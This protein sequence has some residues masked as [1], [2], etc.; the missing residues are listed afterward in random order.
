MA[1]RTPRKRNKFQPNAD[2]LKVINLIIAGVPAKK[3]FDDC[4]V[5]YLMG[6]RDPRYRNTKNRA[7]KYYVVVVDGQFVIHI[8]HLT[9]TMYLQK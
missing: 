7:G 6:S 1:G 2:E 5:H 9:H 4:H 3:A 8:T